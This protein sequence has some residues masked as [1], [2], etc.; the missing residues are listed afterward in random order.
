MFINKLSHLHLFL[1]ALQSVE[2]VNPAL[3]IEDAFEVL[4]LPSKG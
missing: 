2:A 1:K 4:V 3:I